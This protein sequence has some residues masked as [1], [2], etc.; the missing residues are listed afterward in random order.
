VAVVTPLLIWAGYAFTFDRIPAPD[1]FDGIKG[2]MRIEHEGVRSYL[3]GEVRT[4]GWWWYFPF[5]FALKT[6]LTL[7]ILFAIAAWFALHARDSRWVFLEWTAAAVVLMALCIPSSIDLGIRYLLPIYVPLAIGTAIGIDAL[8]RSASAR[9]R[10]VAGVLLAAHFCVS[11]LA[12]PAYFP[13][14]NVLAGRDPSRYLIDSNLDWGQD[15]LRLRDTLKKEHADKIA[16][17][18]L[19]IFDYDGQRFPPHDSANPWQP[20]T[21]WI[22]VSD[23]SYRMT[24]VEGGWRWL[25]TKPYRRIGKS[26]RLYYFTAARQ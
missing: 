8:Y 13:Y 26:I 19:A 3:C 4:H 15:L 24:F 6:T 17:S 12:H 23:Y 22:A 10:L 7:L 11:L 21:G 2:L 18:V 5:A 16:I 20:T 25:E 9:T 14:F 1:F